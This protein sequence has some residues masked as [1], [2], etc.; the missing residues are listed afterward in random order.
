[1]NGG[2]IITTALPLYVSQLVIEES[3][4][5]DPQAAQKTIAVARLYSSPGYF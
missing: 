4:G 1:M 5:G 3:Q 2:T